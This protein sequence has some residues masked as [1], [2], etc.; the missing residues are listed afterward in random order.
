MDTG[1]TV[2][3]YDIIVCKRMCP[4]SSASALIQHELATVNREGI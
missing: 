2:G 3:E 4:H 1:S